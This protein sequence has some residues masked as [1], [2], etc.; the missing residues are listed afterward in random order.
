[1]PHN[2]S[3]PSF[4]STIYT[5]ALLILGLVFIV[6]LTL[7]RQI[8]HELPKRSVTPWAI[9]WLD[10]NILFCLLVAWAMFVGPVANAIMPAGKDP[11]PAST[12]WNAVVS[13]ALLQGGM[14]V[15]FIVFWFSQNF[16]KRP[17]FNMTRMSLGGAISTALVCFL[18]L[19]PPRLG[20]EIGWMATI[21]WLN[22]IG[23][24]IP[25][26]SQEVVSFFDGAPP[27]AYVLLILLAGF[28]APIVEE[29]IFRAG[30]Y[31]FLKGQ[32]GKIPAMIISSAVFSMLHWNVLVFPT[33]MLFGIALCLSY[34]SSGNVKV[35]ICFHAIFNLNSI[36][37][38]ALQGPHASL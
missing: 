8:W 20:L 11:T 10:I 34:E 35:P 22:S 1:M 31:R 12:A 15:I 18:L 21:K 33:L 16:A 13:G 5:Y 36:L 6:G 26:D 38:I 9:S 2:W 30:L 23:L 37:L 25:T 28:V 27:I 17:N 19:T 14:A 3:D 4:L 24:H 29:L 7:K 32:T